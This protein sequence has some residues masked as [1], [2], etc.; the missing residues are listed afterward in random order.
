MTD[1]LI[2]MDVVIESDDDT[3]ISDW[4]GSATPPLLDTED[5][6]I[7]SQCV[8][9]QRKVPHNEFDILADAIGKLIKDID[10]F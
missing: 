10:L 4:S 2:D 9:P 6:L 1:L 7:A 3:Y 8:A 5:D